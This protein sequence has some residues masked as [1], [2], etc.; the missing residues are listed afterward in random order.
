MTNLIVRNRP[1]NVLNDLDR[2]VDAFFGN[3]GLA[4]DRGLNR[5]P[6]IDVS[7]DDKQYTL[8]ADIPGLSE[9]DVEIKVDDQLLT[10]SS[11]QAEEKE[12]KKDGYLIRERRA[13]SFSRS[14]TLPSDVDAETISAKSSEGVLTV[15][16]PKQAKAQPKLIDVK[17]G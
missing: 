10:I 14:F 9:K 8:T 6:S 4:L 2:M 1:L 16:L 7:E 5:L 13:S 17:R 12:E 11:K 3:P 15:T